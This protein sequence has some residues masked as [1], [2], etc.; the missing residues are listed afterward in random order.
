[1]FK[2]FM[3]L[4]EIRRKTLH[5]APKAEICVNGYELQIICA[6]IACVSLCVKKLKSLQMATHLNDTEFHKTVIKRAM[7]KARISA[8][9]DIF[10]DLPYRTRLKNSS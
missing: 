6:A 8:N 3:P 9:F 1:M 4:N 7:K 2:F 10:E 5:K